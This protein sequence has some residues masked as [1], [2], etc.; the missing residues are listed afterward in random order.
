M[1]TSISLQIDRATFVSD[2]NVPVTGFRALASAQFLAVDGSQVDFSCIMDLGAPF[3]VIPFSLWHGRSLAWHMLGSQLSAVSGKSLPG[4]LEWQG[5]PCDLG[6]TVVFLTDL[7]TGLQAGPFLVVAKFARKAQARSSVE[8]AA[9]LGLNF[10]ADNST[11]L[12]LSGLAGD[13]SGKLS[14]S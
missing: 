8:K 12:E 14:V 11:G 5:V 6:E 1:P 7:P 10:L 2:R 3:C 13:L 4:A 9:I